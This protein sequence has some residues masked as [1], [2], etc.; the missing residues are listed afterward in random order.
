MAFLNPLL[1]FGILGIA[2][3]I[4]IHLLA[5]KKIKRVVWAAMRFLKNVVEKNQQR[6]TLEDLILLVLRCLLLA[7]LALALARPSFKKGGL[8]GFGDSN[9]AAIIAI[10]NSASMSQTDGATSKFEQAQ[11]TAEEVLDSLPSGSSVAVWLVSDVVKP[12]IPEPTHDLALARKAIREAQRSDRA[13]EMPSALRR[14]VEV[15]GR[16]PVAVKQLFLITDG[17][18]NG[19][20]QLAETRA[21]LDAAKDIHARFVVVGESEQHNLGVTGLRMA[22]AL[23]PV[24]V[25]VRFEI[26]VANY[27]VEEAK[28]V[29]VSLGIDEEP[30]GDDATIDSIPA[31]E[32]KKIS[33]YATFRD[34]GY[35]SAIARLPADR[36]PADDQRALAVR[37]IGEINVLLVDGDPGI[38]PRESE[39]FYL[40]NAL[41]PVPPE[42]REKYYIKTKTISPADLPT[43]KLGDYEAV[44]LANVADVPETVLAG[45]ERYLRTG[46]GLIVFPGGKI[47][48]AFYNAKMFNE[49]AFLPAAFGDA[50]GNAEQQE[51]FFTLQAK[52]YDHP[53]V[54][55]WRDPAAGSLATAHFY[56][57]F[58]LQPAKIAS[59]RPEAGPPVV[60]LNYSD[61]QPAVMER[62]WGFGRVV[63]F[64]STVDSAWNDLCIRP[65]F[66]PL[67]HRTLGALVTRQE[68][69]LNLRVGAKLSAAMDAELI[70]KD[71]L[72][73]PPGGKSDAVSLQRVT[74]INGVPMLQFDGTERAGVYE[75]RQGDDAT[76]L[77]RFAAQADPA[78]SNLQ[79]LSALDWK[80]FDGV[81]QVFHWSPGMSLRGQ[82]QKERTGNEFWMAFVL[83]ALVTAVAETTLS[84]Q[85]S[86]S[87]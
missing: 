44:V 80:T 13:T 87:R 76:P 56:R 36:N 1:L 46:G 51:Q 71:L 49:R 57:A 14:M 25:P 23:A 12:V 5:K 15:L 42:Q 34:A 3:P 16:Q 50:H 37:V 48:P 74:A 18:S 62:T 86:R 43:A 70:G 84:N 38:E 69:Q 28:N 10:D 53:I 32:T 54:S 22:S 73:K 6:L 82:L 55:I 79:E 75:V 59:T 30:P 58:A 9:E 24:N 19:W 41:T 72:I 20:K 68:E 81:A 65:I 39:V 52:G 33:L 67:I 61:G 31:G 8:A 21:L 77:L 45:L 63:Q 35:H 83:L 64:S 17:Q 66:V 60:V 11:K 47:N 27:G 4:I 2:S 29:Q 85:W 26:E 7:V 40:H 78:E